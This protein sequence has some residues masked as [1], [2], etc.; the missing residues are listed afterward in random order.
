MDQMNG[1]L[2]AVVIVV[3]IATIHSSI[4]LA[5]VFGPTFVPLFN[6]LACIYLIGSCF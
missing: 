6:S 2:L 3:R 4:P 1:L 5:E